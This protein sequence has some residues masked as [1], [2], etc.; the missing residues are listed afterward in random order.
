VSEE[1]SS[2]SSSFL[3]KWHFVFSSVTSSSSCQFHADS[4]GRTPGKRDVTAPGRCSAVPRNGFCTAQLVLSLSLFF[5]RCAGSSGHSLPKAV[6]PV[7]GPQPGASPGAGLRPPAAPA[8]SVA[9]RARRALPVLSSGTAPGLLPPRALALLCA[10][11]QPGRAGAG[12]ALLET[13]P[14]RAGAP[15]WSAADLRVVGAALCQERRLCAQ[16]DAAIPSSG[17]EQFCRQQTSGERF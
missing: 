1:T 15:A 8:C 6:A 9:P 16:M 7:C 4:W 17:H 13:A 14:A 10:R 3:G 5:L 12:A 11:T 2:T